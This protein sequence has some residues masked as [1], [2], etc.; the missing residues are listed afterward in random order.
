MANFKRQ[1]M[2]IKRL[3]ADTNIKITSEGK[4]HLREAIGNKNF[5]KEYAA[6]KVS[7]WRKEIEQRSIYA[8]SQTQAAFSAFM[9]GIQHKYTYFLRTIQGME[10]FILPLD[11]VSIE[12]FLPTLLD[13]TVNATEV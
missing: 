7:K 11:K 4:R 1:L 3:F 2:E 13:S 10:E 9:H 5:R 12:A 8:K 6:E